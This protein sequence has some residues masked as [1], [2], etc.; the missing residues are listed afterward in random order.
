[1]PEHHGTL[2]CGYFY[3]QALK[4]EGKNNVTKAQFRYAGPKP[5]T[6]ETAI[7]MLADAA[8][9]AVRALNAP[10]PDQVDTLL[11][12]IFK[13]RIEDGQ[14]DECPITMQEILKVKK[15][16]T[17]GLSAI[18]HQRVNYAEKITQVRQGASSSTQGKGYLKPHA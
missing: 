8:E 9:S 4:Q 18:H 10:T 6:R 11:E 12:V 16:F 3:A 15:S 1:M 14:F 5:Q 2:I 7:V 13:Q 17:R